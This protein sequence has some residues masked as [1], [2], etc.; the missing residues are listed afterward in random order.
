MAPTN[1]DQAMLER[2]LELIS[3]RATMYE[4]GSQTTVCWKSDSGWLNSIT[5]IGFSRKGETPPV[6]LAN[7]YQ[8]IQIVQ[9]LLTADEVVAALRQLIEKHSLQLGSGMND[10]S[11]HGSFSGGRTR[12]PHSEWSQWPADIFEI[13][14]TNPTGQTWPPDQPLIDV[15][16]PYYPSLEHVLSDLFGIRVQGWN[17]YLRG[18]VMIVLPDFRARISK[19]TVAR[20]YLRAELE[21]VFLQ[22]SELVMKTYADSRMARLIQETTRLE[23]P[24]VQFDLPDRASFVGM[25]LLAASSGELL[26]EKTYKEGISWR[27]PNVVVEPLAPEIEQLLLTGEGETIEFKEKLDSNSLRIA[28]TATAFANTTG[29]TIVFG[30]DDDERVVGCDV[31]GMAETITNIL[32]SRCDPPPS[33]TVKAVKYQDKDLFLVRVA[34]S[35]ATVHVVKEVGPYIR[36]N[37]SNRAPTSHELEVLQR[38]R[39]GS[40]S[41]LS[42]WH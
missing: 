41:P 11:Y 22:P 14:L 9:R 29:G 36:A 18:Q 33:F 31:R 28:K 6:E 38:R 3:R 17:N 19:L 15:N 16:A 40:G 4:I 24:F 35:S 32:R 8:N 25:A 42:L 20:T 34:E 39:S 2:V 1:A 13:Q 26:D 7:K 12:Q 23:G 21:C 30:V 27:E 10:L 37:K 5:K